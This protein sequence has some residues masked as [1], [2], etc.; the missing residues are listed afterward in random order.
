MK[1][2]LVALGLLASTPA[3]AAGPQAPALAFPL[4]C[5]IGSNC[6]IQHYL[7]LD[8]GP[9]V[10][11][12]HGGRRTYDGHNGVDLRVADMATAARTDVLAAAPGRVARLRDG[13]ADVSIRASGAPDVEG[14]ECGNGVV[15]DHG[16]GWE[17]QYCHLAKGSVKVKVGDVVKA[18]QPIARVGLSG[19]TEFAHL[20]LSVRHDGA[21][22]DPFVPA[23]R[24]APLW[25]AQARKLLSYKA[26]AVLNAG[27]AAGPVDLAKIEAAPP[28]KPRRDSP[29]LV[30]YG[31][32]IE[33][34]RGDEIHVSLS[35]PGGGL[36]AENRYVL[37]RDKAQYLLF[38][39]RKRPASGWAPGRY[40][41]RFEVRR[42]GRVVIAKAFALTL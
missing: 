2:H 16:G 30:A 4:A 35:G 19:D 31:R 39:G 34:E 29:A 36:L 32:A 42:G 15:I 5:T 24:A 38:A 21:V 25:N 7:D 9:G 28:P 23:P 37:D 41:A 12:Y 20:H 14:R 1:A 10:R 6:E 27:F 18:G 17:T 13:V 40:A 33:L 8:A 26:G 11:D 3:H 22:V